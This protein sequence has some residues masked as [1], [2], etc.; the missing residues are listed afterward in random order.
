LHP[1]HTEAVTFITANFDLFGIIFYLLAFLYYIKATEENNKLYLHSISIIFFL[2][3]IFTNEFVITLPLILI[4]YDFFYKNLRESTFIPKLKHY[5]SYFII[6]LGFLFI[7]FKLIGVFARIEG[8]Q[9]NYFGKVLTM[10]Q[11]ITKYIQILFVPFNLSVDHRVNI[12]SLAG[13]IFFSFIVLLIL[14]SAFILRKRS[15]LAS[16]GILWFFITL[17]PVMNIVPI[18]RMMAEVYLYLPSIGFC[19]FLA[20]LIRKIP[21]LKFKNAKLCYFLILIIVLGSY[22]VISFNRNTIWKDEFSLWNNAIKTNPESSKAHSNL[23][24]E[25]DK[26]E[27]YDKAIEEYKISI[28][29]NP[30]RAKTY[31][32]LGVVYSKVEAVNEAID[33]YTISLE[34]EPNGAEA[35]NNRGI[36]YAKQNLSEL[37]INDFKNALALNPRFVQAYVNLGIV[38][39][40]KGMVEE[41]KRAFDKAYELNPELK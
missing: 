18:Q 26:R 4:L 25:L 33:A 34:L 30:N 16:F 32:N 24:L 5:F 41:A 15:K 35:Y 21:K 28:Q 22:S 8:Y 10:P 29:L 40:N 14:G 31:F 23:A 9:S 17:L 39:N 6:A 1:V 20:W 38:Y 2:L 12:A 36:L 13:I 37:A 27:L 11:V 7:R 3:G 19:I